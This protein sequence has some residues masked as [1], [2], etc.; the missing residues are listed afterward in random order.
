MFPFRKNG[1]P[2]VTW[3]VV[4]LG[5]MGD[6]YDRTRHNVGFDVI[7]LLADQ[8][9][10]PVQRLKFKA[11]TNTAE[12]GGAK[13][14]LMKPVT[15]MNLSGEAVEQAAAFYKVPPERVIVVSDEVALPPG[16][17][18]VRPS[19]SAGGHN[20]LKNIIAHLHS[21][22]FPRVRIGVGQ[23]PHPDYDMADWVLGRPQGA[24]RDAVD[25]AEARA[26]QAVEAII[27][28]GVPSAMNRFN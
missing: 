1:A 19:G 17:L 6:Q 9:N 8:L 25:G 11:L 27:K 3:L 4:G 13:V 2:G 16:K 18:R 10:I 15:F 20:G 24:D 26:A 12:L 14:L 5:N 23:K 7:D 22:Q 21:D 28:D